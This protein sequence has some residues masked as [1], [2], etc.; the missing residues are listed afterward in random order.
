M[1]KKGRRTQEIIEMIQLKIKYPR[2]AALIPQIKTHLR[3]NVKNERS[4]MR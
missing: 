4:N 3:A 1:F 2:A